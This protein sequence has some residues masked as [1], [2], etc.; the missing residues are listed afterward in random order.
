LE[1]EFR[2]GRLYVL[3]NEEE[4]GRLIN[5][6]ARVEGQVRGLRQMLEE[7]RYCLD[8]VQQANA[9]AAAVRE[10]A[11]LI[12]QDHMTAGVRFAATTDNTEG[13][14]GD[15]LSVLRAAIRPG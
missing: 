13:A 4:K 14:I 11:L 7:D 5:R 12:M 2:D 6:L 9:I 1:F 15:V 8:E 10:V 3:R